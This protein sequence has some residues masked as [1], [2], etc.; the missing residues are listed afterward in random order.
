MN[1][2][3]FSR[4][5]LRQTEVGW[6]HLCLQGDSEG[7]GLTQH[8]EDMASGKLVPAHFIPMETSPSQQN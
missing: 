8:R 4:W 3:E 6:G 2:I 5:S 1:G 7:A